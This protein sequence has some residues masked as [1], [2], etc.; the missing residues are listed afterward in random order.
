MN[1]NITTGGNGY[2]W[3][4]MPPQQG[5]QCPVCG[6][7]MSPTTPFCPCEGQGR[8]TLTST[9]TGTGDYIPDNNR[10]YSKTYTTTD[11]IVSTC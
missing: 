7:I 2:S 5:W 4:Q 3:S 1:N 8:T 10:T 9:G 11:P 6:R